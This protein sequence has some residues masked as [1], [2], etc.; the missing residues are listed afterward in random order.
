MTPEQLL[1]LVFGVFPIL[2]WIIYAAA[3]RGRLHWLWVFVLTCVI[4]AG[5]F[6]AAIGFVGAYLSQEQE[7][8]AREVREDPRLLLVHAD[9]LENLERSQAA[10]QRSAWLGVVPWA[11]GWTGL[12]F[13]ASA[14]IEWAI[15]AVLRRPIRPANGEGA[16]GAPVG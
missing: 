1:L 15:R 3:L 2:A 13:L 4:E 7:R 9:H 11:V 6:L 14:L 5:F 16:V 8:F 12:L 10:L